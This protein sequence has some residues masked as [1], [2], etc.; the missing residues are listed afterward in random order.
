META[1][2][3]LCGTASAGNSA[4]DLAVLTGG[5]SGIASEK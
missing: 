4:V 5:V 1:Q 3:I 2:D